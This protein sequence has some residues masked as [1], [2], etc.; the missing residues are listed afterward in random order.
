MK[1]DYFDFNKNKIFVVAELSANHGA[2][3]NIALQTIKAAKRA[4]ADAI[5]LQTF[6]PDSITLDSS[7]SDFLI[8]NSL[9]QN[10]TLYDLYSEACT[11]YD[12]HEEL[13]KAAKDEGLICFSS[14]FDKAAVDLL[15]DLNTPAYKVASMEISD[16]TLIEYIASKQKPIII[17]TGVATKEEISRAIK[18]C[19]DNDNYEIILL[20]CTSSYPAP[21][22]EANLI[23][24]N[25]FANEFNVLTGLSDHTLGSLAPVVATALGAKVIEKHFILNKDIGGPDASFSMDEAEFSQMVGDI[26]KAELLIGKVDYALTKKQIESRIYMRSLY[27]SED[28]KK[29][30]II[31]EENIKKIRPGYGLDPQF[32]N[33]V[34][35]KKVSKDVFKGDRLNLNFIS[36][37]ESL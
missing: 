33:D 30:E 12:W 14:P 18:A 25:E 21:F 34:L 23:M 11:P 8:K 5:K 19:H 31:T 28:I 6:T 26:R 37:Y 36:N 29:G 9:W 13:F 1:I 35:G 17:S 24:I 20:Q 2:D 4:G 22:E 10:R 7:G 27:V 3:I 15:E 16:L 32:Y